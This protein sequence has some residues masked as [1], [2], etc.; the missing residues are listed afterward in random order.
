MEVLSAFLYNI[1]LNEKFSSYIKF[2]GGIITKLE[3]LM[4]YHMQHC[5]KHCEIK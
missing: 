1:N 4:D 2:A 3:I 5:T